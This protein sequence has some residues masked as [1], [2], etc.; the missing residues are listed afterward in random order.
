ME[1]QPF[2]SEYHKTAPETHAT[3]LYHISERIPQ[4][5]CILNCKLSIDQ[6]K[7]VHT[8]AKFFAGSTYQFETALD[9]LVIARPG[10]YLSKTVWN[11]ILQA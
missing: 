5:L 8:T 11:I 4:L 6:G 10:N 2:S 1:Q 7:I 9:I 3:N